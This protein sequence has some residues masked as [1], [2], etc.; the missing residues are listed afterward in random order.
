MCC[1]LSNPAMDRLR[2]SLAEGNL[3]FFKYYRV[4]FDTPR[5]LQAPIQNKRVKVEEDGTIRSDRES[6]ELTQAEQDSAGVHQ[7]IHVTA[8]EPPA[9]TLASNI[10]L[11]RVTVDPTDFV[12]CEVDGNHCVFT[13]VKVDPADLAQRM[14]A[15][16]ELE[17]DDDDDDDDGCDFCGDP[18]CD[19]E[20]MDD[21]DD[22]DEDEDED[23]DDD[24]DD[25]DY[26]DDDE[27]HLQQRIKPHPL[28]ALEHSFSK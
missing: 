4:V 23:E 14:A 26:D 25:D 12:A 8:K 9:Y 27:E 17:G 22:D 18:D 10:I 13:K 7:G 24:Y 1:N 20:C 3:V 2:A 28:R 21:D 19:G 16:Q 6:A 11:L 15:A 5:R